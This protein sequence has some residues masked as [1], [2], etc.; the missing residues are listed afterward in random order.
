MRIENPQTLKQALSN[1]KLENLS[2][3][4]EVTE[5]FHQALMGKNVDTEDVLSLLRAAHRTDEES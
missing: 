1:M 2:P 3:S 5:L 4:P